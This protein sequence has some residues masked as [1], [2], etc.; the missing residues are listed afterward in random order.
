MDLSLRFEI[1]KKVRFE[2]SEKDLYNRTSALR[3]NFAA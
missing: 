2:V 1:K 3:R